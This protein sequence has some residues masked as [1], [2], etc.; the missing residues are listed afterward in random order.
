VRTHSNHIASQTHT[1]CSCCPNYIVLSS[2]RCVWLLPV[3]NRQPR[4]LNPE[5]TFPR[6][7]RGCSANQ[8]LQARL[9]DPDFPTSST[10][11]RRRLFIESTPI[12]YPTKP[13]FIDENFA[14]CRL[15]WAYHSSPHPMSFS[16][17]QVSTLC[18][19]HPDVSSSAHCLLGSRFFSDESFAPRSDSTTQ[20]K[21]Q[22]RRP[23]HA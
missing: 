23:P 10:F 20:V 5:S 2:C 8:R 16:A 21:V 7:F 3:L 9:S 1:R 17:T 13:T 4:F 11:A 12:R 6:M 22:L 18:C 15:A 14:R 19:V